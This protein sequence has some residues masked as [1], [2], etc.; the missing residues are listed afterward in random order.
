MKNYLALVETILNTGHKKNDRTGIGTLSVFGPQLSFNL[1]EGFPL[2]TSRK[3]NIKAIIYELLWFLKGDTNIKYL[4]ENGVHI[5]DDWADEEGNL[6]PIYGQQWREY[7]YP[8]I[9]F[10]HNHVKFIMYDPLAHFI[11]QISKNPNSRRLLMSNW[12]YEFL[13]VEGESYKEAIEDG[14]MALP[15]CHGNI[16]QAYVHDGKLSLKVYSRSQDVLIGTVFN[17]VTYALLTHILAHQTGLEVDQL[18]YTMGD[19][20]IYLNQLEQAQE[21]I[22]REPYPLPQF[23]FSEDLLSLTVKPFPEEYNYSDFII[24]NYQ[25]HPAIKIPVNS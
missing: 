23:S 2:L 14:R 8:E 1:Q 3:I 7:L 25:H 5:W 24:T 6:G 22:K 20:H 11:G 18:I 15:P 19:T 9:N 21:L 17:V 10:D 4:N 13:P 12:R 16:I